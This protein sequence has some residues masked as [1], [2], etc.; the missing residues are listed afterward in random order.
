MKTF[1]L[2]ETLKC[3]IMYGFCFFVSSSSFAVLP[4]YE[5]G[6]SGFGPSTPFVIY[7]DKSSQGQIELYCGDE[8]CE[9]VEF[10]LQQYPGSRRSLIGPLTA[11]DLHQR[12]VDLKGQEFYTLTQIMIF[13]ARKGIL[14]PFLDFR[15]VFAAL[16]PA[17]MAIDA[18]TLPFFLSEHLFLKYMDA[19]TK[20]A[21][22]RSIR[23]NNPDQPRVYKLSER[24]FDRMQSLLLEIR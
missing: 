19:K 3:I 2:F 5:D 18:I 9:D 10:V 24:K 12:L 22:R 20:E 14:P 21:I 15:P 6:E 11:V 16:I 1:Q 23:G 4:S 7:E 13:L 8:N 17:A